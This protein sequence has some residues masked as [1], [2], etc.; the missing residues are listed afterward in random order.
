MTS[1]GHQR[2]DGRFH[3][4]CAEA[5]DRPRVPYMRGRRTRS[6]RS[7]PS[8]RRAASATRSSHNP[9]RGDNPQSI[10]DAVHQHDGHRMP[11]LHRDRSARRRGPSARAGV[12]AQVLRHPAYCQFARTEDRDFATASKPPAA[13]SRMVR[14]EGA[15][16]RDGLRF[17]HPTIS[18]ARGH[19]ETCR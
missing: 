5:P 4:T 6:D 13:L 18:L 3:I 10:S 17:A 11:W 7:R 1:S 15:L 12:R 8:G 14:N 9:F 2:A 19:E 16:G